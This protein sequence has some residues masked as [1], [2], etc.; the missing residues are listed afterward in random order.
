M[1]IRLHQ[2][3]I[4]VGE[5]R[6][7]SKMQEVLFKIN[8]ALSDAAL[9][10]QATN[11]KL[12]QQEQRPFFRRDGEIKPNPSD[13]NN[14]PSEPSHHCPTIEH[15]K[16]I[17]PAFQT[18]IDYW[19]QNNTTRSDATASTIATTYQSSTSSK[20]SF[21][22]APTAHHLSLPWSVESP[23]ITLMKGIARNKSSETFEYDVTGAPGHSLL[24]E[25]RT[26]V[27][28]V[29]PRDDH[30]ASS[31]TDDTEQTSPNSTGS[32]WTTTSANLSER[33]LRLKGK[34]RPKRLRTSA[35]ADAFLTKVRDSLARDVEIHR[36]RVP[37]LEVVKAIEKRWPPIGVGS[38]LNSLKGTLHANQS[39]LSS[40]KPTVSTKELTAAFEKG[41]FRKAAVVGAGNI[42]FQA[43]DLTPVDVKKRRSPF[44]SSIRSPTRAQSLFLSTAGRTETKPKRSASF[45]PSMVS[46][47]TSHSLD[48]STLSSASMHLDGLRSS[49][50]IQYRG[51]REWDDGLVDASFP[52]MVRRMLDSDDD[53]FS[54]ID[55][56]E[57]E[58][59]DSSMPLASC[60][61]RRGDAQGRFDPTAL[62]EADR[63]FEAS[64]RN[65]ER[66]APGIPATD[67]R[68]ESPSD[69]PS[70]LPSMPHRSRDVYVPTVWQTR[71]SEAVNGDAS[72]RKWRL[73]RVWESAKDPSVV[74]DDVEP[75]YLV[76]ESDLGSAISSLLG[77][78][79]KIYCDRHRK[80]RNIINKRDDIKTELKAHVA[81]RSNDL[82]PSRWD[83]NI[84]NDMAPIG[85]KD[86]RVQR[87]WDLEGFVV[88]I[89]DD[90]SLDGSDMLDFFGRDEKMPKDSLSTRPPT[91]KAKQPSHDRANQGSPDKH[92]ISK[93]V[94]RENV[95]YNDGDY[96][97]D[98]ESHSY[99]SSVSNDDDASYIEDDPLDED[100]FSASLE[101]ESVG[102]DSR[103]GSPNLVLVRK[104]LRKVE[105]MIKEVV[106]EKGK[107]ASQ[108][109][110]YRRLQAKCNKY[111]AE[112]SEHLAGLEG[113][114][115]EPAL[116][117]KVHGISELV[118]GT[119]YDHRKLMSRHDRE[120]GIERNG[121]TP[122]GTKDEGVT[123][124]VVKR[125]L[126]KTEKLLNRLVVEKG[127]MVT[128][129]ELYKRLEEKRAG[130]MYE[131][132]M[133]FD[134]FDVVS[135]CSTDRSDSDTLSFSEISTST[136]LHSMLGAMDQ[137]DV[138]AEEDNFSC[139][140]MEEANRDVT[141]LRR[142]AHKVEKQ[143]QRIKSSKEGT[144]HSKKLYQRL[145][146][147]L[148]QY[149]AELGGADHSAALHPKIKTNQHCNKDTKV[150]HNRHSNSS[151]SRNDEYDR[152]RRR[153]Q[154]AMDVMESSLGDGEISVV[155]EEPT[156]TMR[157]RFKTA[158]PQPHPCSPIPEE[159]LK[160]S[161]RLQFNNVG[162]WA[163][164][165]DSA[166][167][168]GDE[169]F[170]L[171]S[172]RNVYL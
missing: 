21:D 79:E 123:E 155:E 61:L 42:A 60:R 31:C 74:I 75:D 144:A 20:C 161:S 84:D 160:A 138:I 41:I 159:K 129:A 98:S 72:K 169:R 51:G 33:Q 16:E 102:S 15:P 44:E 146:K 143:M 8:D 131:L 165:L 40:F 89:D 135:E 142:K 106:Q 100:E 3:N 32:G 115:S 57:D 53:D 117:P 158:T 55:R 130:Y 136:S 11:Q 110:L 39:P 95:D 122:N 83:S 88:Y 91:S 125:K 37:S 47:T 157:A 163:S 153:V 150:D 82:L 58:G 65:S 172:L 109:K 112:L 13:I 119:H 76:D 162:K 92:D 70:G 121:K 114:E 151:P 99:C 62:H 48:S 64:G 104:K 105:R 77:V 97:T 127:Q 23:P 126:Q 147:K 24:S 35:L 28:L 132:G 30:W 78:P 26:G 81:Y 29:P 9:E 45:N 19:K 71:V 149:R 94:G 17:P 156:A 54:M 52:S 50:K 170:T 171:H 46:S 118:E 107:E 85:G 2:E 93:V 86:F 140:S 152:I 69:G 73:R 120:D 22:S 68:F 166:P 154:S 139:C 134:P 90:Q 124:A 148:S 6:V 27:A 14:H 10:S 116:G 108:Q 7:A 59:A 36:K 101:H 133:D 4:E 43:I 12:V 25:R 1:R 167:K 34:E 103:D 168:N 164:P 137:L 38:S 67:R 145:G 113:A 96:E 63:R 49:Y 66:T 18:S 128:S 141:I 56:F 111:L 87:V 5:T 80:G